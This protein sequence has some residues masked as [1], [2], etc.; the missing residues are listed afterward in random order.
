MRGETENAGS[1][2]AGWRERAEA[3]SPL[4]RYAGGNR[5]GEAGIL[6]K[7]FTI[8]PE[9]AGFAVEFGQRKLGS[10]TVAELIADRGWGALYLDREASEPLERR[11][12]RAGGT[13]TLV[14][15]S[16]TPANIND[17]FERH[18]V[19]G[20]LDCLVIDIDGLDYPVW[21]AID[22][23][24]S[25]S[26][27]V[28]EFNAHV[29]QGV[30]ATIRAEGTGC[31]PAIRTTGRRS[32]PSTR[33]RRARGTDS[34]TSTAAGTSTSCETRSTSRQSWHCARR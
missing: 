15:E 20:D 18:G 32:R 2:P 7:L 34:S 23:R 22:E 3:I 6:A 31:T 26:L 10:G 19:P 4:L 24:Y 12:A 8:L 29:A 1:A 14:R 17:L 33:S 16:V 30:A 27:V 9:R 5:G 25:P 28:I 21:E 11:A 13:I